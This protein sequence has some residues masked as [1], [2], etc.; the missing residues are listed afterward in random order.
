MPSARTSISTSSYAAQSETCASVSEPPARRRKVGVRSMTSATCERSGSSAPTS[1]ATRGSP[2]AMSDGRLSIGSRM[3]G[4]RMRRRM[5]PGETRRSIGRAQPSCASTCQPGLPSNQPPWFSVNFARVAAALE[6]RLH[7]HGGPVGTQLEIEARTDRLVAEPELHHLRLEDDSAPLQERQEVGGVLA[8]HLGAD[9][10]GAIIFE[11]SEQAERVA[12]GRRLLRLELEERG[13]RERRTRV[14]IEQRHAEAARP[15]LHAVLDRLRCRGHRLGQ[16]GVDAVRVRLARVARASAVAIVT[17]T[18]DREARTAAAIA[19]GDGR[20]AAGDALGRELARATSSATAAAEPVHVATHAAAIHSATVAA[21]KAALR[22]RPGGCR[23]PA[24]P[25]R[26]VRSRAL[27][28]LRPLRA[29]TDPGHRA[30]ARTAAVCRGV[31]PRLLR[32]HLVAQ[33]DEER[34]HVLAMTV[35]LR[36]RRA[37]ALAREARGR[38]LE[39][40]GVRIRLGAADRALGRE[41][42]HDHVRDGLPPDVVVPPQESASAQKPP[43]RPVVELAERLRER[44]GAARFT[45]VAGIAGF[46]GFAG[47]Q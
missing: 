5:L 23:Q 28:A 8:A 30:R 22:R 42:L 3:Y 15:Y 14:G 20:T 13:R 37:G 16:P 39:L 34:R 38:H 6:A 2:C 17:S 10:P 44:R 1:S 35:D 12:I 25:L 32:P 24:G 43:E 26:A 46:A 9:P 18:L 45:G 27:R 41:V 33:R 4:V 47:L 7:E 11:P 29:V 40:H 21:A 36:E 31:G 19:S